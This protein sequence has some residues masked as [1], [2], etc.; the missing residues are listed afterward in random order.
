MLH[1]RGVRV[2]VHL[3][4]SGGRE[5]AKYTLSLVDGDG[6]AVASWLSLAP[7]VGHGDLRV[8]AP[9]ELGLEF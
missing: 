6:R 1:E 2:L 9:E 3:R 7:Q 4:R 5:N 8:A